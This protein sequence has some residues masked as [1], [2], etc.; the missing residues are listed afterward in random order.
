MPGKPAP[1]VIQ[2]TRYILL[3]FLGS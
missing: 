2:C 3:L 1:F